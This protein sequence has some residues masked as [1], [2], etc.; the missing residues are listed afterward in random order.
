MQEKDEPM[1]EIL[2]QGSQMYMCSAPNSLF[3]ELKLC[4]AT[5]SEGLQVLFVKHTS[6]RIEIAK[7]DS[8]CTN[9][10]ICINKPLLIRVTISSFL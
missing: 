6:I 2:P 8:I 3:L 1:A 7:N 10:L 9:R 5:Q 4:P